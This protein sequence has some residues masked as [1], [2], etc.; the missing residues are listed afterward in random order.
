MKIHLDL[1]GGGCFEIERK[2]REP[3]SYERFEA[4]C[5]VIA[6]GLFLAFILILLLSGAKH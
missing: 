3:M 5:W 4:I 6:L 2:P 1:P